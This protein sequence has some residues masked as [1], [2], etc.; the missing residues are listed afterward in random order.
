MKIWFDLSNSPHINLFHPI[1]DELKSRHEII[2]TCRPLANTVEMLDLVGLE[3]TV[4]GKHYGKKLLAKVYGYPIRVFQLFRFLKEKKPDVAIS[5]SSF[6]SPLVARLLGIPSIYMNDNE[7]ATGNIP[8][9]IFATKILV[10]EF[11]T[12]ELVSRQ[13][14]KASKVIR[15]P[16]VK[17]G[18]YLSANIF[19][20][21]KQNQ[22]RQKIYIRPEPWVAQYY[23]GD[24]NFMDPLV[25]ALQS[26]FDIII[27]PRGGDQAEHYLQEKFSGVAVQVKPLSLG[28]IVFDCDLFIGAGG[29]MTREIALLGIPT[30]SVYQDDLLKV[31]EFMIQKGLM[32]Y[33]PHLKAG[34]VVDY[35]SAPET[36]EA[37]TEL[38]DKGNIARQLVMS[39]LI[40]LVDR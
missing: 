31:D 16:G 11:L 19:K 7:H 25:L 17:E 29:T 28:D 40:K 12:Q 30:I 10:P 3:Y 20:R 5:Q 4:V 18:L 35:L 23:K 2:I 27:L 6:H 32:K 26:K 33:E 15:Y 8:S 36:K 13:F 22:A 24:L 1:I 14:G 38:L 34:Q 21:K 39:E 9:F 37:N